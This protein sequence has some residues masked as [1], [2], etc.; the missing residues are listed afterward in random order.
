MTTSTE[1]QN[2]SVGTITAAIA[3][4]YSS[5]T[6]LAPEMAPTEKPENFSRFI[7]EDVPILGEE[8]PANE[9]FV[10]REAWKHSDF[11]CKND[12]LSYLEDGLYNVYSVMETSKELWNA[13]EKKYKTED[14]GLKKFVAAKFLDF[15][16]VDNKSAITQVQELQVIVHDLLAKGQQ[17]CRKEVSWKFNNNG[18]KASTSKKRKK[19]SGPKNYPRKKKFKG[20]CH[21]CGKVARKAAECRAPK[22]DKKKS[23]ANM[24]EKND[25]IDDLCDMLSECNLVRNPREWWID[26]GATHHVCANKELLTSY[27]PTGPNETVFMANFATTKIEGTCKIA[28]KITSGKI[29]TLNDVLHVPEMWKNLVSTSLL[30]KNGFKCVFVSDKVVV[31]YESSN[32]KSKRPREEAKET[33]F[34]EENPRRSKRQ[35]TTISF[36]PY[37]LL[38]YW[39]M[40]L[41]LSK[42][43]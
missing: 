25:E 35:R 20:N 42:K 22:K 5:R 3:T 43:Q 4:A 15:K 29:V 9:R 2:D 24:I 11:L 31:K 13:L 36:G 41:K 12:I 10:V 21:S 34:D 19:S 17:G 30:V 32:G 40:S 14:A 38:S 6:T 33:T 37:F 7:N 1:Q 8:T 26:S 23:Q 27:T 28:L 18:C 16:M 39:K